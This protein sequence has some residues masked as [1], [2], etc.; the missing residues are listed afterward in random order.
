MTKHAK[1]EEPRAGEPTAGMS[2][3]AYLKSPKQSGT[4]VRV[5]KIS[6]KMENYVRGKACRLRY[7]QPRRPGE[8]NLMKGHWFGGGVGRGEMT[9]KEPGFAKVKVSDTA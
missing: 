2:A 3:P 8:S 5:L 4:E 9:G 6:V 7:Y 1:T